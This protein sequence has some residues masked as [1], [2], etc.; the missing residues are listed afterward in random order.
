MIETLV[1]VFGVHAVVGA[2][3]VL[4]YAMMWLL[5]ATPLLRWCFIGIVMVLVA[6]VLMLPF[7][8]IH[9]WWQGY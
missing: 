8:Y 7:D 2:L 5:F 9:A 1:I 6:K 3:I 4:G